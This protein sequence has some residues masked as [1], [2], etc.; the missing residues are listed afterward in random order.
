MVDE[1][2]ALLEQLCSERYYE[3]RRIVSSCIL[4]TDIARHQARRRREPALSQPLR[5][6]RRGAAS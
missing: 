3:F 5:P 1:E 6:L 2:V 4:A